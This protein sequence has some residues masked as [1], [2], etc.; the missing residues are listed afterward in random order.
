MIRINEFLRLPDRVRLAGSSRL[1]QQLVFR[2]CTPLWREIDFSCLAPRAKAFLTDERLSSL[3][4]RV[5]ARTVTRSFNLSGCRQL[6]GTCL[7]PLRGSEVLEEIKLQCCSWSGDQLDL[8]VALP[9]LHAW[10]CDDCSQSYCGRHEGRSWFC[11][12][13]NHSFCDRHD[14]TKWV[15]RE[16]NKA[17]CETCNMS[18]NFLIT[19]CDVCNIEYCRHGCGLS[20]CD[21]CSGSRCGRCGGI[22]QCGFCSQSSCTWCTNEEACCLKGNDE[23]PSKKARTH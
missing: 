6:R 19:Y 16:C 18:N 2:D 22:E 5:N 11:E 1:L 17:L 10:F 21:R 20:S 4:V 8:Q 7:E 3:L 13:C 9:V 12:G 23:K 15:C 14:V